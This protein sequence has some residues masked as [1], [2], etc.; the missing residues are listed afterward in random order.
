MPTVLA[1]AFAFGSRSNV[2]PVGVPTS[3]EA[4]GRPP[5]LVAALAGLQFLLTSLATMVAL[6]NATL[7]SELAPPEI[8]IAIGVAIVGAGIV[9]STWAG[10]WVARLAQ[11]VLAA[12]A[13]AGAGSWA[14]SGGGALAISSAGLAIFWLGVLA[15]PQGRDW[16]TS[17]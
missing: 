13:L 4:R 15:S 9:G 12:A 2:S 10:L 16:F 11:A 3:S 7:D 6:G 5:A 14:A 1:G 8:G 17:R